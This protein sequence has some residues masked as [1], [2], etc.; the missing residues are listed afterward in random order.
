MR[1][2]SGLV[3]AASLAAVATGA[4]AQRAD[5]AI[6]VVDYLIAQTRKGGAR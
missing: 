2:P 4:Q 1:I 3:L 5:R 6:Q